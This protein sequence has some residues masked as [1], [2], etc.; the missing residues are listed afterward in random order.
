MHI[1]YLTE[2]EEYFQLV[3]LAD[4][5]PPVLDAVAD[6]YRV[7]RR[8]TNWRELVTLDDLDA[9]V[10]CHSG[11]HKESVIA[12]LDANKH[13]FVEKPLAWNLREAQ[14]V[15]NRASQSDRIVQIAY[16][17]LYDPGYHYAKAQVQ[18]MRDLGFVRITVLHP[19]NDLGFSPYRLRRGNGVIVEG[20]VDPGI[21]ESQIPG[22]LSGFAG[23]DLGS[24]VDEALGPRKDDLQLR[25][26]YGLI[27]VSLI[28]QIY[29]MHGFL[30]EPKRA[31]SLDLWRKGTS[32]HA[33]VE[34][35]DDVRGTIDWHLLQ[36]LKDYREEYAFFGNYDRVI[37]Q[38]PSP[39]FRNFPSPVIVQGGEGELS[40]E[41]RV[42]VSY[43]EAFRNEML[44]FYENVTQ[45]KQP[46]T[47]IAD[48]LKHH[49]FIQQLID[50]AR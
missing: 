40:W 44:A 31:V 18:K 2:Y 3:A 30:G 17:K 48:A 39:Y 6:R 1:P 16:H 47:S 22:M 11:S 45:Q 20:H 35:P 32:I 8:Y 38:F 10:I 14:E 37:L 49:R 21:W 41:K 15:A 42:I 4:S 24:L 19:H 12:A 27:V 23:G 9:V 36:N 29:M 26:G 25:V 46:A 7:E 33:Q 43:D 5:Y 50:V 34:Y 13:I 28:H